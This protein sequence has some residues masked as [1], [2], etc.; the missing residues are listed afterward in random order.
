[1]KTK[2][3]VPL[4]RPLESLKK[5]QKRTIPV[6]RHKPF[7]PSTG[8]ASFGSGRTPDE[9]AAN[10]QGQLV[11]V[12]PPQRSPPVIDLA[13]VIGSDEVAQIQSSG[14][15]AFHAVGDTG[16]G[17]HE[18]L[19]EVVQIMAMDFH[20][21]N[22]ADHPAFFLHL[23]DVT[24]NLVFGQVESKEGMYQPQFYIP[25]S[26]YPGKILAIP[27]NHDSNPQEDPKSIDVFQENFCAPPPQ[28]QAQLTALIQSTTRTPMYQPGVYFQLDAPFVQIIA[29]FSNGGEQEGVITGPI[30][31]NDQLSFLTQQLKQ[32]KAARD[33]GQR[34][35]L[36]VA[37]HHPPF[38]GGGGHDGSSLMLAD[39]DQAF[40]ILQPDAVISG[41]AHNY[42]RFTREI[43]LQNGNPKQVPYVVAGNGGHNITPMKPGSNRKPVQTPIAGDSG[44][45]LRQYFNG[46]GHLLLTV[47]SHVL[48]IDLIGTRTQSEL[49]VDSVTVNLDTDQI[50]NETPPFTHPATG[51]E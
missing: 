17:K 5:N 38:S 31:G 43:T 1:M 28:T 36:V 44:S 34:R 20:R 12:P 22:P 50:S 25:Y 30:V 37:V 23:G 33:Q 27:G 24:Y 2:T 42:Q 4:E 49:P 51:E 45:N 40:N 14:Q 8:P 7:L 32:I 29:L 9:V 10:Q 15:I 11:K 48:T 6:T 3:K 46:F 16:A 39:L 26:D 18:D 35:A 47:T 19:G 21:P 13:E 41:H